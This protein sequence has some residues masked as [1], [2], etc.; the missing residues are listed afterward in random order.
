MRKQK[1]CLGND[2]RSL[3]IEL[4][5]KKVMVMRSLDMDGDII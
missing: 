2:S 5:E 1:F 3:N 4:F